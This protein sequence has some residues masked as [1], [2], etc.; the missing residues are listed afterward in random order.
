[1]P[2][3]GIIGAGWIAQ[4]HLAELSKIQGVSLSGITDVDTTRVKKLSQKYNIN[5]FPNYKKLIESDIDA[6]FLL[7]P[8]FVRVEPITLAAKNEKHIFCEKPIAPTLKNADRIVDIVKRSGI[9][10]MMGYVLR[11]FPAFKRMHDEFYSFKLGELISCWTRRIFL[12]DVRNTWKADIK[13][14]GGITIEFYTHDIDWLRWIGGNPQHI[15]GKISCEGG[16]ESNVSCIMSFKRGFGLSQGSWS[17][18]LSDTSVG[19]IGTKGNIILDN[20]GLL[21]KKIFGGKES[22]LTY[23]KNISPYFLEDKYFLDC[24]KFD[25]KPEISVDDGKVALKIAIAIQKSNKLNKA[26]RISR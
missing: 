23:N 20:N 11:F 12:L 21:R 18:Q 19:I 10:F 6:V 9:K 5:V 3:I 26:V 24:I 15:Y 14:G 1:M 8:P 2:K 17:S 13:K 16:Y 25:K 4:V 7:T 22:I